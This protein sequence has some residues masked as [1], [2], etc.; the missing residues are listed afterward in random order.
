M[1]FKKKSSKAEERAVQV[2]R[3][4]VVRTE[5]VAKELLNVAESNKVAPSTLDFNLLEVQTM[6]RM[7][8][9]AEWEELSSDEVSQLHHDAALLDPNLELKQTY[10]IEIFT[11]TDRDL[12]DTL[13][14][15][16]GANATMCKVYMTVKAG[17]HITYFDGFEEALTKYINKKKLRAKLLIWLFDHPMAEVLKGMTARIRVNEELTFDEQETHLIAE[18]LE[19]VPTVNDALIMHFEK[20]SEQDREGDRV[21]YSKRGYLVSVIEDELLIEYIKPRKGEM[22]RNCRGE[23]IVPDEP[24][25][26]NEPNFG[27]SERIDKVENDTNIEFRAKQSGYVTFE[28]GNYDIN[29]EMDV[30]EISFKTTGSIETQLD[31]DVSLNVK[32]TDVFKDAIGM[33]MEVEVNEINIEGNVG[34]NSKV[35]ARKA[36]IEGQTHQSAEVYADD[37]RI[38]I[39]KG[40]AVGKEVHITRL[41]HGTVDAEKVTIQQATGGK[42]R[43]REIKIEILGSHVTMTAT[44]KIE[45]NQLKGSENRFIIDPVVMHD[46]MEEL[47]KNEDMIKEAKR[48]M[49]EVEKE[50]EKYEKLV[51]DN[52]AAFIDLKKRLLQYKKS[53]VQMPTSF[54]KKYKQFQRMQTHLESLKK[55]MEQ[56]NERFELLSR[57]HHAFQSDIFEAQ[58]ICND[59]WKGHNEVMFKMIEPEIEVSYV[60]PEHSSEGA[61]MLQADEEE[62]NYYIVPVHE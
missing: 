5:N 21:D 61:L 12:L 30:S 2:I 45:V 41:E 55:E 60:P 13:E 62:E 27:V 7:G 59:Q 37:L 42:V 24:V 53:G 9:G 25:I 16:I 48:D 38:N 49:M 52:H 51:S 26:A 14:I 32:E 29:T 19:P 39:H 10:E 57:K 54:V 28:G 36:I 46:S 35:R 22:G 40:K 1:L 58:V 47:S 34:S 15:G 3:P 56:K 8:E 43:A 31:A 6:K 20:K 17:S 23:L 44:D 18:G 11:K 50:I 33:G 4:V